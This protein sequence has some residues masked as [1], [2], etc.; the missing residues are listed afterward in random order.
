MSLIKP[1]KWTSVDCKKAGSAAGVGY[2][3]DTALCHQEF[4]RCEIVKI[5]KDFKGFEVDLSDGVEL[6]F[7]RLGTFKGAD[8]D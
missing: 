8:V 5:E 4:P 2:E 6:K 7:D 1:G 3:A